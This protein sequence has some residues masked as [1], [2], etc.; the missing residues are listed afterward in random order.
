M[1]GLNRDFAKLGRLMLNKGKI[2][3]EEV[4]PESWYKEMIKWD[5]K[6]NSAWDNEFGWW[7]G[8]KDYGYY[9]AA[10]LWGQYVIV[11]PKKNIIITRFAQLNIKR[12]V[13]FHDRMMMVMDQL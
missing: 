5:L 8:P 1:A 10:G 2:N 3:G 4:F 11:Y 6:E 9:Y 13:H 12:S 7:L